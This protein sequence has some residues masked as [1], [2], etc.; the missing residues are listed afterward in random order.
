MDNTSQF[1]AS[2]V[3]SGSHSDCDYDVWGADFGVEGVRC[4]NDDPDHQE[5][6]HRCICDPDDLFDPPSPIPRAVEGCPAHRARRAAQRAFEGCEFSEWQEISDWRHHPGP[7]E[8][9]ICIHCGHQEYR[10]VE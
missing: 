9:R 6:V 5:S 3:T 10:H 4:L 8:T 7:V 1:S 2:G